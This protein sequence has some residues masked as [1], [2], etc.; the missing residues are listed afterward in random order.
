MFPK[1]ITFVDLTTCFEGGEVLKTRIGFI[2]F[3]VIV[4]S[5]TTL[6]IVLTLS[7]VRVKFIDLIIVKVK[8]CALKISKFLPTMMVHCFPGQ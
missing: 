7:I 5:V 6:D 3:S 1:F 2:T 8:M 4:V